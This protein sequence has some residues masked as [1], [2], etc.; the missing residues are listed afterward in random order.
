[1][2]DAKKDSGV[3]EAK[4]PEQKTMSPPPKGAQP[5]TLPTHMNYGTY[6]PDYLQL[7]DQG[8]IFGHLEDAT[9]LVI[10]E[11]FYNADTALQIAIGYVPSSTYRVFNDSMGSATRGKCLF[12]AMEDSSGIL[13]QVCTGSDK[14]FEMWMTTKDTDLR[15]TPFMHV[16]RDFACTCFCLNRPVVE[17]QDYNRLSMGRIVSEFSC[18][19]MR[20]TVHDDIDNPLFLVEG[21]GF[22]IG[23]CCPCFEVDL[24]IFDAS[25]RKKV[26]SLTKSV[27]GKSLVSDKA[28]YLLEVD[29][30]LQ[31]RHKAVLVA[32]ALF[33]DMC[34]FTA[35]GQESRDNS[36]LGQ[37]LK[38]TK[39]K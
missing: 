12:S 15:D 17:M 25:T 30:A 29:G 11:E 26:G 32:T 14:P 39:D 35:G 3:V 16:N 20:F 2:A 33:L 7:Q 37:L 28:D 31:S 23:M 19:N 10:K 18:C 22:Q 6:D 27:S 13:R 38:A 1:M 4:Q 24:E 5:L 34:Y 9:R 8:E 21:S 36:I